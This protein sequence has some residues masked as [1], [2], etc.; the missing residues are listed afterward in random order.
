MCVH[1]SIWGWAC[2]HKWT[3][4]WLH[5]C[6]WVYKS[7]GASVNMHEC[8]KVGECAWVALWGN[9]WLWMSV[10][11]CVK[12]HEYMGE[13][14]HESECAWVYIRSS[15][16]ILNE[17]V[18]GGL[19]MVDYSKDINEVREAMW[20]SGDKSVQTEEIKS[21]KA[22]RPMGWVWGMQEISMGGRQGEW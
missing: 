21:A 19:P 15:G 18:R 8:G 16:E 20:I 1:E 6:A 3:H 9:V 7:V 12:V 17:E 10:C 4:L 14:T 2:E 5:E 22:L 13:W 11:V